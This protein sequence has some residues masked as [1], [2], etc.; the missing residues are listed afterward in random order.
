MTKQDAFDHCK[1]ICAKYNAETTWIVA[2]SEVGHMTLMPHIHV[3]VRFK[4]QIVDI[5]CEEALPFDITLNN[6]TFHGRV[7]TSKYKSSD[8]NLIN[9][10]GKQVWDH[11][12]ALEEGIS[13]GIQWFRNASDFKKMVRIL[14]YGYVH[15]NTDA[16]MEYILENFDMASYHW[17]HLKML[18]ERLK[19]KEF[20][21]EKVLGYRILRFYPRYTRPGTEENC[22]DR[23]KSS[24]KDFRLV[25]PVID[26]PIND[27]NRPLRG[28][29]LW[30]HGVKNIGKTQNTIDLMTENGIRVYKMPKRST[31]YQKPEFQH[32]RDGTFNISYCD[33]VNE[34]FYFTPDLLKEWLDGRK[35]QQLPGLFRGDIIRN[36]NLPTILIANGSI[37]TVYARYNTEA[38]KPILDS[39]TSRLMQIHAYD[40]Q[41][42]DIDEEKVLG[43]FGMYDM[44]DVRLIDPYAVSLDDIAAELQLDKEVPPSPPRPNEPLQRLVRRQPVVDNTVFEGLESLAAGAIG[45][46][47]L[48]TIESLLHVE[49]VIPL[50]VDDIL[51]P[52]RRPTGEVLLGQEDAQDPYDHGLY[53]LTVTRDGF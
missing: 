15:G 40:W 37:E 32:W 42:K 10:L 25:N 7:D 1:A 45:M 35:G 13:V 23:F 11:N 17:Q 20:R 50:D 31:Q 4:A 16:R 6:R 8:D 41:R 14:K 36:D 53:S 26:L 24:L 19:A 43:V 39:L 28:P 52:I 18:V 12:P 49:A 34:D 38:K 47:M 48:P 46:A 22:P 29:N 30:I 5:T 33:E 27:P 9:Y 2:V 51:Q 44:R 21:D 3:G